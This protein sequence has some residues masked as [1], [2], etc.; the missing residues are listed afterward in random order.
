MN[1]LEQLPYDDT[2]QNPETLNI[3]LVS[4][5]DLDRDGMMDMTFVHKN[6]LFIYYNKMPAKEYVVSLT[7]TAELCYS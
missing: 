4:F 6:Q 3:P 7:G 5:E 1:L 2:V